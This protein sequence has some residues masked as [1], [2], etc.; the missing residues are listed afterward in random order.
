MTDHGQQVQGETDLLWAL[1]AGEWVDPVRVTDHF[2]AISPTFRLA[3]SAMR[4]AVPT[5][6]LRGPRERVETIC[7]N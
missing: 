7:E 2:P 4:D 1:S 3:C 5:I 6:D